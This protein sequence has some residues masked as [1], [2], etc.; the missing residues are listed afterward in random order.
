MDEREGQGDSGV[1]R[2]DR[3]LVRWLKADWYGLTAGGVRPAEKQERFKEAS[4][5]PLGS[6]V[7]GVC[8]ER[9]AKKSS[10]RGCGSWKCRLL[11]AVGRSDE[12]SATV[13]GNHKGPNIDIV[14]NR[15]RR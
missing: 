12:H 7:Q 13:G 6:A 3:P 10:D 8:A 2:P 4:V 1:G 9:G 11:L 15:E 14:S 5:G